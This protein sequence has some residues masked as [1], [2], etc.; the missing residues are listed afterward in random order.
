MT[1]RKRPLNAAEIAVSARLKQIWDERAE[2][3]GLTQETAAVALEISQGAV[4]HYLNKRNAVG[5]EALFRWADLL[6][7]H[8]YEIDPTFRDRLPGDLRA[9]VDEMVVHPARP[10]LVD[11]HLHAAP[12]QVHE[13]RAI[14]KRSHVHR[15]RR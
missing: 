8:P 1:S 13:E 9:A 14:Y 3:L 7:V 6:R 2:A 5:F 11:A 4:S 10:P 15:L 12:L